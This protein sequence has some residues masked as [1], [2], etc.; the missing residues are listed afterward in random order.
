M[1]HNRRHSFTVR[2][3][4][5]KTVY[6]KC[7]YGHLSERFFRKGE[8]HDGELTC[9]ECSAK[10]IHLSRDFFEELYNEQALIMDRERHQLYLEGK[11]G[12]VPGL[13]T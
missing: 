12:Y 10:V 1:K 3:S 11:A 8:W 7:T 6:L 2:A 5:D 9:Q 13:F 4:K